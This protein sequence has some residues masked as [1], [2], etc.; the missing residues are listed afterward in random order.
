MN[1]AVNNANNAAAHSLSAW[2]LILD[3]SPLVKLVLLLLLAASIVTWAIILA[4]VKLTRTAMESN[5]EF[6]EI[7][8]HANGLDEVNQKVE[9]FPHSP[10]AQVFNAGYRELRKLPA[11]DRT[12]DG[13][14]EVHNIERALNRTHSIELDQMEKYVDF[15]AST[16]SAAPFVGLFG[17]VWGIM[18]SF[19]NIG[20]TGS[21]SLAVVAP[22]I[23]EALIATAVG[24]AAAIPAAIAYNY[25]LNKIKRI[26]L[27]M[28]SFSQEF[29]N[30]IQRSLLAQRK[31]PSHGHEQPAQ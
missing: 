27:D 16:A 28:E 4:K 2:T 7:F 5:K 26:S 24:L 23:S 18:S 29:L 15:L 10:I 19:Q 11:Q 9:N 12:V 31:N 21:A 22:G 14:P 20:A 17:T 3:A 25:L 13:V 8:W 6:L 1:N 30:M